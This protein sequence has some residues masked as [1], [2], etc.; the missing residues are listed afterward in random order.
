MPFADG[1]VAGYGQEGV[2][3]Q[4][5]GDVAVPGVPSPNLVMVEADLALG[6]REALLNRPTVLANPH[7][8]LDWRPF[9]SVGL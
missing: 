5:E 1:G 3:Q 9:G 2:G 8:F 6:L 4:A 7:E